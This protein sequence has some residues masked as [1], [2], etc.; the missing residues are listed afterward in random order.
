MKMATPEF[1]LDENAARERAQMFFPALT[2]EVALYAALGIFAFF[3]RFFLLDWIPLNSEEARQALASWNFVRGAPDDFTGSPF[4][5]TANALL[6]ALF[7]ATDSAARFFPAL[8]GSALVLIPA[9]LRAHLGRAGALIASALFAFAPSLVTFSRQADGAVIA[10]TF[11]LAALAFAWRA[12]ETRAGRD[13]QLAAIFLALA[14]TSAREV[15]T[16]ILAAILF[17][18]LMRARREPLPELPGDARRAAFWFALV[19]F[20][21]ATAFL[22]HREGVGAA[23]DL[24]G[25]WLARLPPGESFFD[26]LRLLVLYDPIIFLC[27]AFALIDLVFASRQ[28][29][30]SETPLFAFAL[31]AFVAFVVYSIGEDKDAARVVAIVVPLALVAAWYIGAWWERVVEQVRAAP[32]AKDVLLTQEAPIFFLACALAAFLYFVFAE[33]ALR[34]GLSIADSLVANF[35]VARETAATMSGAIVLALVV[36][37]FLSVG[38]LSLTTLGFAR[39]KHLALALAL[40]ILTAWTLRQTAL[41]NFTLAPNAREWLTPRVGAMN[42]RDLARDIESVS[43]WRANDA[44]ALKIVMDS[45]LD[46]SAA[47]HLRDFR[48]AAIVVHPQASGGAQA[49]LLA[50]DAPPPASG[51]ISQRYNVESVPGTA[52]PSR[53]RWLIFRDVGS[54]QTR[55]AVLWI[56]GPK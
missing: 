10:V 47:W 34:G 49:L 14:L 4:L 9:L 42:A 16:V 8:C 24:F 13:V 32:N 31:W 26:P 50:A 5:F 52:S 12:F 22:M 27:G 21:V 2:L 56:P 41:V 20:G 39:S 18:I 11:A 19:F 15:W 46:A 37:A 43:R 38:F 3:V 17:L 48:D 40:T 28:M 23:F 55:D 44:R 36:V 54:V 53:L 30:L 35:G 6:F 51:W 33:F 1:T 7:G 29:R 45:S 25:A